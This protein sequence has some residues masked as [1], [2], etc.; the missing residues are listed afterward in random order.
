MQIDKPALRAGYTVTHPSFAGRHL[1]EHAVILEVHTT[2]LAELSNSL[3]LP[4]TE[5]VYVETGEQWATIAAYDRYLLSSH[6][7]VV[8][9][10]YHR[11]SRQRLLKVVRPTFYPGVSL[12]NETGTHQ[13]GLN[14]LVAQAFL[15]P[16]ADARLRHVLPKDGNNLNVRVDNLQWGD[17]YETEDEAVVHYLR[18]RGER[19]HFS[20]LSSE[21]VV[22]IRELVAQG[23][24]RQAVADRFGVSRPTIS[25]II[26]G[27][28]RR[29]A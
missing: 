6:G 10:Y 27:A 2:G 15:P 8:S 1:P 21:Q 20:K 7:K 18:R 14:R 13:V 17:L 12:V 5:L 11:T 4:T 3:Y 25:Y 19:H 29:N 28:T 9:L 26:S 23:A 16:P 22:Q 24:T